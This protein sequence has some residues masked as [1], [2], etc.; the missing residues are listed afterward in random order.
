MTKHTPGPWVC[1]TNQNHNIG[2]RQGYAIADIA[3]EYSSLPRYELEA[4][5]HL[6]AAAPD[7]LWCLE[8]IQAGETMT[9][10]MCLAIDAAIRMAKGGEA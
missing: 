1:R 9:P 3:F 7:M 2:T 10:E 6:I 5:A 8:Q 4:N